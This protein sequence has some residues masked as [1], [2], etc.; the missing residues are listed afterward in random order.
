MEQ[1]VEFPLLALTVSKYLQM[2]IPTELAAVP[3][4]L[5][6]TVLGNFTLGARLESLQLSGLLPAPP[7]HPGHRVLNVRGG[8]VKAAPEPV[9]SRQKT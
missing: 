9:L 8:N 2:K 4:A 1:L 6:V 7:A 3:Q 5:P